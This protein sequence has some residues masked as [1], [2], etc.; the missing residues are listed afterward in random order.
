M[1][2]AARAPNTSP[3]S[4]ELLARRLAPWTPVQ[5]ASPAAKR[6]A[7]DVPPVEIGLDATHDVVRGRAHWN[8]VSGQIE[9]GLL[10][11]VGDRRESSSHVVVIQMRH[12]EDT[13]AHPVRSTSRTIARATRSRDAR[14]PADS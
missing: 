13:R 8:P 2:S 11:R 4:S 6:P 14:S 12:R 1:A 5:A 3:S 7:I 10:A 9:A